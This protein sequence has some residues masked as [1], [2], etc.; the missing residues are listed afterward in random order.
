MATMAADLASLTVAALRPF[1]PAAAAL[2]SALLLTLVLLVLL[3]DLATA[4]AEQ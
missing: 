4:D 1:F 3:P 2:I